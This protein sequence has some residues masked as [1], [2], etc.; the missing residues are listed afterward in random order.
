MILDWQ[1][2]ARSGVPNPYG[3]VAGG[4]REELV[5]CLHKSSCS[6]VRRSLTHTSQAVSTLADQPFIRSSSEKVRASSG[7]W[8]RG[9]GPL[10]Q[11]TS[12]EAPA[13]KESKH[14]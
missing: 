10:R 8:P 5:H 9:W 4:G 6:C 1:G 7:P 11:M 2:S 3:L 12:K 13:C 14:R